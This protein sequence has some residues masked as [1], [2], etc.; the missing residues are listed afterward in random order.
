MMKKTRSG[1]WDSTPRRYLPVTIGI[2]LLHFF[3]WMVISAS[4]LTL[5]LVS[6][7]GG[8][9]AFAFWWYGEGSVDWLIWPYHITQLS[10][11]L[12]AAFIFARSKATKGM[13]YLERSQGTPLEPKFKWK[14]RLTVGCSLV[15]GLLL[16]TELV[17][18]TAFDACLTIIFQ[19][20]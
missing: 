10:I 15:V 14:Y 3:K 6:P 8:F 7:L 17:F 1:Y 20:L 9:T 5:L 11:I 18:C 19:E 2:D 4:F 12:P 13:R 16:V